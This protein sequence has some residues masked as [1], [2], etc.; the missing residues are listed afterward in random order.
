MCKMPV[1]LSLDSLFYSRRLKLNDPVKLEITNESD[2]IGY[3]GLQ[4]MKGRI[5]VLDNEISEKMIVKQKYVLGRTKN[6][7]FNLYRNVL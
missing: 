3:V 4:M 1:I 6:I 2:S 5:I 7:T